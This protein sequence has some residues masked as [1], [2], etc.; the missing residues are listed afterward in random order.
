M[1]TAYLVPLDEFRTEVWIRW[2]G[3]DGE[4]RT[5]YLTTTDPGHAGRIRTRV[6]AP[7]PCTYAPLLAAL[8]AWRPR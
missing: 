2:P 6:N 3:P 7:A 5:A 1:R 4:F 8:T